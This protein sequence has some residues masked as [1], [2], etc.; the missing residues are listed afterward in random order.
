M[1]GG[2]GGGAPKGQRNGNYRHGGSTKEGLAL[3]RHIN[4]LG[5]LLKRL[6]R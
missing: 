3:L 4:M 5:R 2:A 6:P 1:H